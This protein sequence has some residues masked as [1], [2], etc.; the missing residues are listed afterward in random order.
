M[1]ST[2]T[3]SK[4][5]HLRHLQFAIESYLCGFDY[6]EEEEIIEEA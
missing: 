6:W 4:Q 1:K 2:K 5:S 3:Q